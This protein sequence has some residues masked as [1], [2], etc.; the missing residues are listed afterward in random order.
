MRDDMPAAIH[1]TASAVPC[2]AL[3]GQLG[4]APMRRHKTNNESGQVTAAIQ[5]CKERKK[6]KRRAVYS[7]NS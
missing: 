2:P 7:W 6:P 1:N 5:A 4:H 3:D